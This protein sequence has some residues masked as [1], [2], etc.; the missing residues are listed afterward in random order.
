MKIEEKNKKIKEAAKRRMAEY[1]AE[2]KRKQVLN[3]TLYAASAFFSIIFFSLLFTERG[4]QV[5]GVVGFSGG[6][7]RESGVYADCSKAENR[8][9]RYCQKGPSSSEKAWGSLKHG[10]SAAFT[11]H[12]N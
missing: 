7:A 3:Y 5:L 10:G 4:S 9:I 1:Q 12:G 8:H 2:L 6:V 11:L